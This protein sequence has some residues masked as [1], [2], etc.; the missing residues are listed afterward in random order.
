MP[1]TVNNSTD[2]QTQVAGGRL[3]AGGGQSD[4]K[5]KRMRVLNHG[6][7]GTEKSRSEVLNS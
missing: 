7:V 3:G 6:G 4:D 2:V 5:K 1:A